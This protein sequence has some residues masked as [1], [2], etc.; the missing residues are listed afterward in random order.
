MIHSHFKCQT[1]V[2]IPFLAS[3]IRGIPLGAS[4][5]LGYDYHSVH[6]DISVSIFAQIQPAI[7]YHKNT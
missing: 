3:G 7:I 5:N 4:G 2:R 1:M 6:V